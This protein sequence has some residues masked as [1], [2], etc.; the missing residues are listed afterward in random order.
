MYLHVEAG[1]LCRCQY[2]TNTSPLR[3]VGTSPIATVRDFVPFHN[4][5]P[6]GSCIC[7]DNPQVAAATQAAGGTMV[8]QPCVPAVEQ[9]WTSGSSEAVLEGG[10]LALSPD[11]TLH[12]RWG[13]VIQL[14]STRSP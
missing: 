14:I 3:L 11:S 10:M 7:A 6:F 2:G 9:P 12:C 5:Q 13:G 4:V 8:P 1:G